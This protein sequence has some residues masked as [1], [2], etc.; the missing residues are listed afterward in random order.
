MNKTLFFLRTKTRFSKGKLAEVQEKKSKIGLKGGLLW[1]KRQRNVVTKA[2]NVISVED[3]RPLA[4]RPSHELMSSHVHKLLGESLYLSGKY[5]DYEEK[6]VTTQCKV[7]SLST[8]NVSLKNK[9]TSL[10]DEHHPS[11]DFSKLDMEIVE[12]EILADRQS[13]EVVNEGGGVNAADETA[14]DPSPSNSV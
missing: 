5:L 4:M 3:L 11:L 14:V 12:K 7:D 2:H 6:L 13:K 1:R 8:E 10:S 9:V